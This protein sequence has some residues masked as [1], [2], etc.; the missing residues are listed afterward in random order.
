VEALD[1]IVQ[2]EMDKHWEGYGGPAHANTLG[3]KVYQDFAITDDAVIFFIGQ[4]MWLP[5]VAG[6]QDVSVRRSELTSILA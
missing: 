4:G 3:D 2:R 6:P 1:P 5:E